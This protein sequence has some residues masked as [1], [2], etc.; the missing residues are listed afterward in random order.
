[1]MNVFFMRKKKYDIYAPVEGTLMDITEV[2]DQTFAGKLLGDG[3]A[4]KPEN[5]TV[6]AP[7]DGKIIMLTKTGHAF[8][9]RLKNGMEILIHI[10]ID[11]V[12]LQ[13]EGFTTLKKV[14]DNMKRG[15]AII[16][17]DYT[18]MKERNID[19]TTMIIITGN[20]NCTVDKQMVSHVTGNDCI[21]K[22]F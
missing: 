17:F 2:K 14:H 3:L 12:A 6:S 21:M 13:G 20:N 7:A 1:M 9:M 22:C 10:G 15:E 4:I 19:M 8:G 16:Q 18:F 11:T 5:N